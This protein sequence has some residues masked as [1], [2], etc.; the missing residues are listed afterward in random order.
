ML[1]GVKI[2]GN[3]KIFAI[4]GAAVLI[5][6]QITKYAVMAHLSPYEVIETVPGFFNLVYYRNPGAAFG[7]LNKAGALGK[8]ILLAIS[9]GALFF[10]AS[11]VRSSKD[12][13]YTLGLSLIAGGAAGNLID[14]AR[15][16]SVVDF[17]D[18][19]IGS[20]H[21]PAFN[22]ADSAITV[23]VVCALLSFFTSAK[24]RG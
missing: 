22:V 3:L 14:R 2:K 18:F 6:D 19:Y 15:E 4:T 12:S 8:Y 16:G 9:A 17:L 13:L 10:I 1:G 23:G 20:L 21:W 11:L 5:L 7:I 24:T